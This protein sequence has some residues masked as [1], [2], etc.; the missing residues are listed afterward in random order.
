[1]DNKGLINEIKKAIATIKEQTATP[2]DPPMYV[3][4]DSDFQLLIAL[5][6]NLKGVLR[7]LRKYVYYSE[8]SH[9]IRMRDVWKR[10]SNF[11]YEDLKQWL[12]EGC[13]PEV[14][15]WLKEENND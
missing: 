1:M 7:L 10:Q 11:D 4:S 8:K 9:C 14:E 5:E 6:M 13:L 3:V 2:K 15:Q 12:V